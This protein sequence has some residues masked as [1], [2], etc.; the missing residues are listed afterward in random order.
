M[1]EELK[2]ELIRLFTIEGKGKRLA[3]SK[4]PNELIIWI[5]ERIIKNSAFKIKN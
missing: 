4:S 1:N 3:C 2:A 5:N